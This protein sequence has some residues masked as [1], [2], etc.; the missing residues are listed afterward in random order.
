MRKGIMSVVILLTM[1]GVS[2]CGSSS[3]DMKKT[4]AVV[5]VG[6][7]ISKNVSDYV[8]ITDDKMKSEVTVDDSK[9][10]TNKVGNYDLILS[11][12]GK[13]YI[14]NVDV[15]DTQGPRISQKEF[16][17]DYDTEYGVEDIVDVSDPSG[18]TV[19]FDGGYTSCEF[20]NGGEQ[21]LKVVAEDSYGN[22]TIQDVTVDVYKSYLDQNREDM[23]AIR[24]L[25]DSIVN[26]Y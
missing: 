20:H 19:E 9:V 23:D 12:K 22:K 11:Y 24:G 7:S 26:G 2:A 18:Y 14:V 25:M 8:N 21:V 3:L 10:N 17:I 16:V 1:L 4:S 5:E 6:S 15:K 13:E